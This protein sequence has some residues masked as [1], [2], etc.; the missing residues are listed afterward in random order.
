MKLSSVRLKSGRSVRGDGGS[1]SKYPSSDD[2]WSDEKSDVV[3]LQ[4]YV[5]IGYM[6]YMMGMPVEEIM[7]DEQRTHVV[8]IVFPLFASRF[9][10]V[11]CE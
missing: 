8:I 9:H 6:Q 2:L 4:L 10:S 1:G 3:S 5:L 11:A 7:D